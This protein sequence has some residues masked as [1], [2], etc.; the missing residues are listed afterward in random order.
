AVDGVNPDPQFDDVEE[1]NAK[2]RP[3]GFTALAYGSANDP[4]MFYAAHGGKVWV[5][6]NNGNGLVTKEFIVHA[7]IHIRDIVVDPNNWK[8][9]YAVSDEGVYVTNNG[10]NG[11]DN[12]GGNWKSIG[13]GLVPGPKATLA[14]INGVLLVGTSQGVYRQTVALPSKLSQFVPKWVQF[15]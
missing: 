4:D 2:G 14:L 9:A 15:G 7:D 6:Y 12:S 1:V 5:R 3:F 8:V 13:A 11:W 10:G